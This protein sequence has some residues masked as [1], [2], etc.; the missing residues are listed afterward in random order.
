MDSAGPARMSG[1]IVLPLL[2]NGKPRVSALSIGGQYEEN[3]Q[4]TANNR[5]V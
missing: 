1:M 3:F 5:S 2:W 4:I